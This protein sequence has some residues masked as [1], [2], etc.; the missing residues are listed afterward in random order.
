LDTPKFLVEQPQ[1]FSV[2]KGQDLRGKR[3]HPSENFNV[4]TTENKPNF[5]GFL[6]EIPV[7]TTEIFS[8]IST[9]IR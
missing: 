6:T 2:V 8:G 5:S 3:L 7:D 1:E 9:N 4:E